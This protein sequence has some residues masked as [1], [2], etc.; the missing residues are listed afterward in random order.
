LFAYLLPLKETRFVT[1]YS[2]PE[3]DAA[4]LRGEVDARF[5]QSHSVLQQHAE[6]VTK[7]LMDFHV[8]LEIPR[9]EKHP[10]FSH[11]PELETFAKTERER[12]LVAL[13]R[14]FRL[15]G[16]PFILPPGTPRDRVA[17]LQEAM[18][19]VFQD[20]EFPKEFKKI[21]GDDAEIVMPAVMD[22]AIKEL[23]RDPE[24]VELLNKIAGP[25][26]LPPR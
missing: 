6:W 24:L 3:I 21:V 23:P 18:T 10:R 13:Q 20:P 11:L 2:S 26:P 1:G 25:N 16:S 4:L 8:V 9:G 22:K 14:G 12:Q 15:T 7:G 5:N 17:I 19:K